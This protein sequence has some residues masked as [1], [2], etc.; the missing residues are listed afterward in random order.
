MGMEEKSRKNKVTIVQIR[1]LSHEGLNEQL[2]RKGEMII[3]I[4]VSV[5]VVVVLRIPSTSPHL[6]HGINGPF[7]NLFLEHINGIVRWQK[8][9]NEREKKR[10][11]TTF[12]RI[13]IFDLI[14]DIS[15]IFAKH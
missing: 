14:F 3:F 6:H 9:R 4:D 11:R 10:R 8:I 7:I 12:V 13:A 1:Y 2:K 5:V 15:V